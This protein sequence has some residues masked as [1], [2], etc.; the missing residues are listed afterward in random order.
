MKKSKLSSVKPA[1][2]QTL[3]PRNAHHARYP[4]KALIESCP[5]LAEFVKTNPKGELTI[6]FQRA[7]AVFYLNK[8]LLSYFYKIHFWQINEGY[9]CPPIPGRADYIHYLA[10]LLALTEP[11]QTVPTGKHV[12][13]LDIGTG[14]NCIYPILGEAI[15]GWQ[16]TASDINRAALEQAQQN[17]KQNNLQTELILQPNKQSIFNGV[18]GSKPYFATMCNP[19]FYTSAQQASAVNRLKQQKLNKNKLKKGQQPTKLTAKRNFAGQDAELW[20]DGGEAQFL[21]QM[22]NESVEFASQVKWFTTL[23]SNKNSLPQLKQ[24]LKQLNARQLKVIEM[25]QG[26]KVSRIL[27]WQF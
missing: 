12:Q 1:N 3:H 2:K 22:V 26:Q 15:Y 17:I 10:D 27:A 20:C 25:G 24:R 5:A 14:A 4:I 9:L 7:K 23:V 21:T 6:D 16:F 18:I 19:P 11:E 13:I 8:A